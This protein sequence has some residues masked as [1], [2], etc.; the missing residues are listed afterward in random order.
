MIQLSSSTPTILV[1]LA[2]VA[3]GWCVGHA[4]RGIYF[5]CKD[6]WFSR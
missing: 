2:H 5:T 6:A 1:G 3:G 4:L